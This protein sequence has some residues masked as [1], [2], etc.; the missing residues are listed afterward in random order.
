MYCISPLLE[1]Q[2]KN[3]SKYFETLNYS[4]DPKTRHEPLEFFEWLNVDGFMNIL[5]KL[6][7]LILDQFIIR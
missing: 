3:S 4:G 1:K 6:F 7:L 2:F 5:Y